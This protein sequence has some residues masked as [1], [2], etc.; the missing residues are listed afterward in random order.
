MWIIYKDGVEVNRIVA[1]EDFCQKYY[2][3]NGYSYS[4]YV[5]EISAPAQLSEPSV[6]PIYQ[7]LADAIRSGVNEV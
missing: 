7:E 6:D 2:S 4:L 3:S 5:S 1:D